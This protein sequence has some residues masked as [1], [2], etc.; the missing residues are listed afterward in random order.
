MSGMS[1]NV[2]EGMFYVVQDKI[3]HFNTMIMEQMGLFHIPSFPR[4]FDSRR[5]SESLR[6]RS[7]L[8]SANLGYR[9]YM[10]FGLEYAPSDL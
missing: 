1:S 4:T 2:E 6:D 8:S 9:D 10:S 5:Y 3:K 7:I